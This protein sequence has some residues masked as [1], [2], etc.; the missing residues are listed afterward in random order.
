MNIS[1]LVDA[2]GRPTLIPGASV[3]LWEEGIRY[4]PTQCMKALRK[5][6]LQ[7]V[8]ALE[9]APQHDGYIQYRLSPDGAMYVGRFDAATHQLTVSLVGPAQFVP[10]NVRHAASAAATE[11]DRPEV[12]AERWGEP[13]EVKKFCRK[14]SAEAAAADN[15]A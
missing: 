11:A 3:L 9:E 14:W 6:V 5:L 8:T 7:R 4:A 12:F 10:D 2:G 15:P 13:A 1:K